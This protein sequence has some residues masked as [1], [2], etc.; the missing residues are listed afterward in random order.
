MAE[1]KFIGMVKVT[2][3]SWGERIKLSFSPEDLKNISETGWLNV[4]LKTGKSGK[5]YMVL[6]TWKPE[7]KTPPAPVFNPNQPETDLPF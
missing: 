4:E 7:S 1:V 2:A 6:D 5:K 3:T